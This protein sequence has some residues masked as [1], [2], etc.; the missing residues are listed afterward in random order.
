MTIKNGKFGL[1]ELTE[2]L[3][4]M[5][6]QSGFD[7]AVI[8]NR[9]GFVIASSGEDGFD[10]QRQ[11]AVVAKVGETAALAS[12]QLRLGAADEISIDGTDGRRLVC[13]PV[14]LKGKDLIL[15]VMMANRGQAYRRA[16]N[17]VIS[18]IQQHWTL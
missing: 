3:T 18:Q 11:S 6:A 1:V 13:R 15:A 7:I 10:S 14:P 16:T 5:N 4:T 8:T 2:L 17:K 12:T 9:D